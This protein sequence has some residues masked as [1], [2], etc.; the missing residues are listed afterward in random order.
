M[1]L[2]EEKQSK[3]QIAGEMASQHKRLQE[4]LQKKLASLQERENKLQAELR[5]PFSLG[6][7]VARD[8]KLEKMKK[9]K[10]ARIQKKDTKIEDLKKSMAQMSEKFMQ[11]LQ[12]RMIKNGCLSM[13]GNIEEDERKNRERQLWIRKEQ[14]RG[15]S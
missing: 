15:Y 4:N 3:I 1:M 11:M 5:I 10:D 9:D 8:E 12:V 13:I 7:I 2:E 14:W 6:W